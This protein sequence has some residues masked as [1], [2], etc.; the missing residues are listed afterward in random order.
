MKFNLSKKKGIGFLPP[1]GHLDT[2]MY[3]ECEGTKYDRDIVKKTREK[4][5]KKKKKASKECSICNI[6]KESKE[7]KK[8]PADETPYN[9][10]A[11]CHTT[12]DKDK[13]PEKFE[14]CVKEIKKKNRKSKKANVENWFKVAEFEEQTDWKSTLQE[15]PCGSGE[16]PTAAE[17]ARGIFLCYV[18]PKC[19]KEKL[20]KYRKDVL[21]NPNYWADEPIEPEDYY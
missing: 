8:R 11:V 12:V 14:R 2:Q 15:C 13:D 20:S 4:R 7:K 5:K 17:D 3:P 18:C 6:V 10:W 16:F 21:T 1:K 9:P 19:K